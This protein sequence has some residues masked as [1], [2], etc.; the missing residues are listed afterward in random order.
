MRVYAV[1]QPS[2]PGCIGKE[3]AILGDLSRP[4]G[5]MPREKSENSRAATARARARWASDFDVQGAPGT[6]GPRS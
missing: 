5:T 2:Q 6:R 3:R 4:V 1:G